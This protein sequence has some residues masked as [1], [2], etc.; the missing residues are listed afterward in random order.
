MTEK[1]LFL[2]R[3]DPLNLQ[4]IKELRDGRR[5]YKDI[6]V[7]LGITENTVRTRVKRMIQAGIL[8]ITGLVSVDKLPYHQTVLVAVKLKTFDPFEKGEE[9]SKLK[10]VVSVNVVT[11]RYDLILLV[12][13]NENYSLRDLYIEE[14]S[15]VEG[16]QSLETF[17]VFKSYKQKVPYIL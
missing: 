6:A 14:L 13:L 8:D 2:A 9:F 16:I 12:L 3:L 5:A 4:L 1:P 7:K 11:G 15:R 10:G 17:V